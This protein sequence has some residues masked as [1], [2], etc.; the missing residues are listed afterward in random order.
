MWSAAWGVATVGY[1]RRTVRPAPQQ[2]Q[3]PSAGT[4]DLGNR[5]SFVAVVWRRGAPAVGNRACAPVSAITYVLKNLSLVIVR[6]GVEAT[7]VGIPGICD[8]NAPPWTLAHGFA[9]FIGIAP[10][11]TD[12][13][14]RLLGVTLVVLLARATAL[15]LITAFSIALTSSTRSSCSRA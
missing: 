4:R 12:V 14:K 11:V 2:P 9:C 15:N 7:S 5:L 3:R 10:V 13:A 8:W 6:P 1:P